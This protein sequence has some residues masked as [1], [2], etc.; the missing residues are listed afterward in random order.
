MG[1][2]IKDIEQLYKGISG[3]FASV[4]DVPKIKKK[5]LAT[6]LILELGYTD[7]DGTI[8]LDASGDDIRVYT[9]EWPEDLKPKVK[10]LMTSDIA[11]FYWLGK[12]NFMIAM[13]KKDIRTEGNIGE[14]LKLVP[15]LGPLFKLYK[16]FLENND[17]G[18]LI[19]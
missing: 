5:I 13:L 7:P 1:K 15:V 16:D 2:H 10:L 8:I 3:M 17:M 6:N 18:D 11:H 19:V 4:D 9:G 12:V 14:V